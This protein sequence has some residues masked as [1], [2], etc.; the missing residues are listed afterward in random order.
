MSPIFA[1]DLLIILVGL[2][3]T[4]DI[5]KNWSFQFDAY[6]IFMSNLYKKSWTV[7]NPGGGK[8]ELP[9]SSG[10]GPTMLDSNH[11]FAA[12]AAA[13]MEQ[14]AAASKLGKFFMSSILVDHTVILPGWTFKKWALPSFAIQHC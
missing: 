14:V 10:S 5:V 1:V 8:I 6:V 7:S 12:A 11:L 13:A 2:M 3:M 9:N 4:R